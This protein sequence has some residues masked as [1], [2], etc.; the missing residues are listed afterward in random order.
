MQRYFGMRKHELR[1]S[2][3][4]EEQRFKTLVGFL[5]SYSARISY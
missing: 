1:S 5:F 2:I 4:E 3:A